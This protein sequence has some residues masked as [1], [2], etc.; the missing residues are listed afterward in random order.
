M[1]SIAE[2]NYFKKY[3]YMDNS[4]PKTEVVTFIRTNAYR[5]EKITVR[6]DRTYQK[7]R[8]QI[9]RMINTVP[10]G[11]WMNRI[12]EIGHKTEWA[13]EALGKTPRFIV[14]SGVRLLKTEPFPNDL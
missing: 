4:L 12:T 9:S 10:T 5:S 14:K 13:L 3:H 11:H 8:E 7:T 6:K 2:L 1:P